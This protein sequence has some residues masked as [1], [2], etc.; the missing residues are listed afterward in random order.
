MEPLPAT[1]Q[2]TLAAP[3]ASPLRVTVKFATVMPAPPSA[4]CAAGPETSSEAPA[5][6]SM[7]VAEAAMCLLENDAPTGLA[8]SEITNRTVMHT[9]NDRHVIATDSIAFGLPEDRDRNVLVTAG[10]TGRSAVPYLLKVHPYGFICSDGGRG[11]DDSGILGLTIVEA[12]GLAGATVDARRARMG[13]GLSHYHDGIISAVNKH[14]FARGVRIDMPCPEA[15][16]LLLE[17]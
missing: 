17:G 2:E 5:I 4:I 14:A 6:D 10:H 8:A 1:A 16:R 9:F 12:E 11:M 15:A 3:E 7:R 13:S